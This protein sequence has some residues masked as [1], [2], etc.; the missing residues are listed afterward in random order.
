M[1]VFLFG[2][3]VVPGMVGPVAGSCRLRRV[4]FDASGLA[5]GMAKGPEITGEMI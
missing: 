4:A 3:R 1:S 2:G 5:D